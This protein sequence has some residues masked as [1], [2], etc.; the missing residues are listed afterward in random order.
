[1]FEVKL[2]P[3][4]MTELASVIPPVRVYRLVEDVAPEMRSRLSGHEIVNIN[5]TASGGGVAEML[6]VLLPLCIGV[7]V[8][9]PWFVIEAEPEF[10]MTTKRLHNRI[11]GNRGDTGPLN[12][13]ELGVMRGVAEREAP[14]LIEEL[15]VGDVVILHDPQPAGLAKILHAEGYPIIWRCHVGVDFDNEYTKQAW[16]FLRPLLEGYVDEYV[17]TR[18]SYAPDWIPREQLRIIKPA[19][20]PLAPKNQELSDDDILGAL[21]VSG[22][23]AGPQVSDPGFKRS[24]GTRSTFDMVAD[25]VRQ[26]PPPGPEVP[27][28]VQ[29]SRWDPLKDMAG[30]MRGF[31]EHVVP[32]TDAHLMLVGPSVTSVSDDPEGEQILRDITAEWRNLPAEVSSRV[33][34]VS[35]PMD[36]PEQNG[37]LVNAIQRHAAV[38]AQ[39][40]LAEGFGLTVTEAMFKSKPVVASAVGGIIDQIVDGESGVLVHDPRDL[41]EFGRAVT[42]L[43]NDEEL[44]ERIGAAAKQRVIDYFL[45]DSSLDQWNEVVVTAMSRNRQNAGERSEVGLQ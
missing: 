38:V 32:H 28:V 23:I 22:I 27:I 15:Q 25:I 10:F 7:G 37:A 19:I 16:D 30:V 43:L 24:D 34:L 21:T 40:S 11:H 18:G 12:D 9:A 41:A 6:H 26:G 17:F 33:H 35:L 3:R 39:K 31:V 2:S 4:S 14:E 20:D 13:V 8:P 45:P 44:A 1:M 36:D 5:S 29:V 42:R